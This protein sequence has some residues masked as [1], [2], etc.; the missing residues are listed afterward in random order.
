MKKLL[1]I[2]AAAFASVAA[3]G[4]T[5]A[6]YVQDGLIAQWDGI[7]NVGIGGHDATATVWKDL[8]GNY[9]LSLLA[10]GSWSDKGNALVVEGAAAICSNSLPA[11]VTIEVVYKMT[12]FDDCTHLRSICSNHIIMK[13]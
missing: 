12:N 10:G 7:D 11:Y 2:G 4:Y 1:I 9:D 3:F 8:A 13:M 6:S 5:S